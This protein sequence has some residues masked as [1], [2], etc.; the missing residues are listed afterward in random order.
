MT[1]PLWL[2]RH[3]WF[4]GQVKITLPAPKPSENITIHPGNSFLILFFLHLF[5]FPRIL[6]LVCVWGREGMRSR[7]QL[8]A[9]GKPWELLLRSHLP[10]YLR[11]SFICPK[12][13]KQASLAGWRVQVFTTW[14][15]LPSA[16][17]IS[18]QGSWLLRC[19]FLE[20]NSH[21]HVCVELLLLAEHFPSSL[22]CF[23]W[24]HWGI[25]CYLFN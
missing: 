9:R 5:V 4:S 1:I 16:G 17:I 14:F 6:L 23:P 8:E 24:W 11:Q 12:L 2:L 22:L 7:V 20:Q 19:E 18:I 3:P 13:A 10:R 21:P 25:R 15:H